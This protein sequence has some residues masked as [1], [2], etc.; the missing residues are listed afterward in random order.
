MGTRRDFVAT[1]T[2]AAGGMWLMRFAPL[3]AATQACASEAMREG[4]PF[5]TFTEREATDFEAFSARIVPTDDTPGAREA[6]SVYFA[7]RALGDFMSDLL[8]IV[9]GGLEAMNGRVAEAHPGVV[10]FAD[11]TEA[12]QDEV[13]GAVERED[14]GFF[15]FAKT[16]VLLGLVTNPEYGGNRDHVGWQ[17]LGF[18]N[19]FSYSPPFGYYDR[20][21]HGAGGTDPAGEEAAEGADR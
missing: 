19:D 12:Q 15:F 1:S 9:R 11:L 8:P 21:E 3:I 6:G 10:A 16:L 20:D 17:L 4:L 2:S 13:I 18:E 14:P 5:G 7:D